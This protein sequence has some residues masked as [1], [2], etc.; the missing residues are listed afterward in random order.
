MIKP[1]AYGIGKTEAACQYVQHSLLPNHVCRPNADRDTGTDRPQ[2]LRH[3]SQLSPQ[4]RPRAVCVARPE[5]ACVG[6]TG[7]Q[8]PSTTAFRSYSRLQALH[9][10]SSSRGTGFDRP[11]RCVACGRV[12][13]NQLYPLMSLFSV[14]S[15]L[16]GT[17]DAVV[18]H[19]SQFSLLR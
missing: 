10:K 7:M 2:P 15:D 13:P 19:V 3:V 14:T 16:F 4:R 5:R 1:S 12:F 9:A 11:G 6:H 18:K 8:F 17:S